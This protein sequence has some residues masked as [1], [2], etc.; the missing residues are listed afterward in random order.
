M[1][2][3]YFF[4][5][6]ES[7]KRRMESTKEDEEQPLGREAK[8]GEPDLEEDFKDYLGCE[9]VALNLSYCKPMQ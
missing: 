9:I 7:D 8:D 5:V 6:L 2:D 3:F 1:S 4:F